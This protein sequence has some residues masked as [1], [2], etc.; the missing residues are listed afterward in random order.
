MAFYNTQK[1]NRAMNSKSATPAQIAEIFEGV[2]RLELVEQT[3]TQ[4][5]APDGRF[6]GK[7]DTAEMLGV[8]LSDELPPRDFANGDYLDIE[9]IACSD[10]IDDEDEENEDAAWCAANRR[11]CV[12]YSGMQGVPRRPNKNYTPAPT[13]KTFL[14]RRT[15][16]WGVELRSV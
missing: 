9:E 6:V 2:F 3:A 8:E 14:V 16:K 10:A 4:L 7:E 12:P 1:Y 13:A 11:L 15:G 5:R